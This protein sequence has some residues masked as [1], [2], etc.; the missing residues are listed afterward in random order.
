MTVGVP[1]MV[2]PGRCP[3]G[4]ERGD[5]YVLAN[6]GYFDIPRDLTHVQEKDCPE[7]RR[8]VLRRIHNARG[9][10]CTLRTCGFTLFDEDLPAPSPEDLR[11][12]RGA[13][14]RFFRGTEKS[15]REKLSHPENF[16]LEPGERIVRVLAYHHSTRTSS[17]S[18]DRRAKPVIADCHT[19]FTRDSGAMVL[20][21]VLGA[22]GEDAVAEDIIASCDPDA[23]GR[24]R[25]R[26]V[27]MNVWR[28]LDRNGPVKAWPLAV[29]HP[30]SNLLGSRH[31][32]HGQD[33][34]YAVKLKPS[35]TAFPENYIL[36]TDR[37]EEDPSAP[38]G[39]YWLYYP[40]MTAAE[41]LVFVNYD[42]KRTSPAFV[43]H[44]A[45]DTAAQSGDGLPTR[46]SVEVRVL[47]VTERDRLSKKAVGGVVHSTNSTSGICRNFQRGRCKRE[48]GCRYEHATG[49]QGS[50]SAPCDHCNYSA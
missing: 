38:G 41:S 4:D 21:M 46:I 10:G 23:S 44:G 17:T 3:S 42:S 14:R 30:G 50:E 8:V 49:N 16:D 33:A 18:N 27:F 22:R 45:F 20:R 40:N 25:S 6:L 48:D 29:M 34:D 37:T 39:H 19:D 13:R 5:D 28:S 7:I 24:S 12:N 2:D 43:F 15:L 26:Y 11:H 32:D 47:V 1:Q 36:R 9:A 31:S 35:T